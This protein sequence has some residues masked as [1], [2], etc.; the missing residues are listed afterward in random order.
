MK[1]VILQCIILY[2]KTLSLDHGPMAKYMIHGRC[3]FYPTCSAYMYTAIE[4]YGVMCGMW[5]GTK[6][7]ARCHPWNDGGY[8]PVPL[9]SDRGKEKDSR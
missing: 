8:D 7:I 2:Q 9:Q 1:K 5:M 3:R 4:K 6:R